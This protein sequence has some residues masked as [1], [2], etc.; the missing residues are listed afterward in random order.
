MGYGI[1][2][3]VWGAYGLFTR[4]EMK[5]ERVS[6][7]VL[8]PSAARGIIEAI[9]WKPAISW[10]IDRIHVYNPIEFTNIRRNEVSSKI[11]A[12]IVDSVMKGSAKPLYINTNA[13]RQQRASMVL[14]NVR[15]IIQA[16]FE[17]TDK[18]GETDTVEKHYNIALRKMRNGQ[19]YHNPYFGCREFPA[20]F[21]LVEGDFPKSG[22]TGERDL[23][24]MLYDIDFTN[25]EDIKPT[26][27]RA[28]MRDGVID[29]SDCE[30]FR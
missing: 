24:Y 23:G 27:F 28:I 14:K 9:Y 15:Y 11:S 12:S 10:H 6:Y 20:N 30:V 7:D 5:V 26:F 3:E 16:H 2:L 8:T 21:R 4:P 1:A 17:L 29:L 22:L 19:C 13:D 18:A 25:L